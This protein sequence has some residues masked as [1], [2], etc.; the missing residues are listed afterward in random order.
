MTMQPRRDDRELDK[1][2][3]TAEGETAVRVQLP[4]QPSTTDVGGKIS[5]DVNVTDITL[6]DAS[7]AVAIEDGRIVKL[8]QDLANL[9]LKYQEDLKTLK[10][11]GIIALVIIGLSLLGMLG[12]LIY[13]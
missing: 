5:L 1:F 12:G 10:K 6:T 3:E 9:Q 13:G 7:D 8:E 2:V 11:H 4:N